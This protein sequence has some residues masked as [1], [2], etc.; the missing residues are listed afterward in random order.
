MALILVHKPNYSCPVRQRLASGFKHVVPGQCV[1]SCPLPC[2]SLLPA[3]IAPSHL[4]P[5]T[6]CSFV[7]S[8]CVPCQVIIHLP[9]HHPLAR[10]PLDYQTTIHL[11]DHCSLARSPFTCQITFQLPDYHSLARSPFTCYPAD[12]FPGMMQPICQSLLGACWVAWTRTARS[13][14]KLLRRPPGPSL[15]ESMEA[16]ATSRTSPEAARFT[17]PCMMPEQCSI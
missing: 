5:M 8:T 15:A 12:F 6:A 10:S 9:D 17:L 13:S 11:P 4:T 1:F 16:T 2:D 3:V 14:R 7:Y